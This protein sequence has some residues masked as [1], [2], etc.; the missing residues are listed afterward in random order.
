MPLFLT[1]NT[2]WK[3]KFEDFASSHLT[4]F[5]LENNFSGLLFSSGVNPKFS[6]VISVKHLWRTPPTLWDPTEFDK[7]SGSRWRD[8]TLLSSIYLSPLLP[9]DRCVQLSCLGEMEQPFPLLQIKDD[10][11][12]FWYGLI[13][14]KYETARFT[15]HPSQLFEKHLGLRGQ[16]S[17][18]GLVINH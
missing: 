10:A 18:L 15:S 8:V 16:K 13:S 6:S 2:F 12:Y 5:R 11:M 17:S 3:K 9:K 14:K 4:W 7:T 1:P